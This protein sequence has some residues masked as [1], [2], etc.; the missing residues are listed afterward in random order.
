MSLQIETQ[1]F[2]F[3]N[4]VTGLSSAVFKSVSATALSGTF[5]GNVRFV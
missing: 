2:Q 5:Y 3:N 1:S 4:T